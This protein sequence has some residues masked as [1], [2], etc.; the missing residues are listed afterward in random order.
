MAHD[1]VVTRPLNAVTA[2]SNLLVSCNIETLGDTPTP[3]TRNPKPKLG[4]SK[5]EFVYVFLASVV[6]RLLDPAQDKPANTNL[7]GATQ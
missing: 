6:K 1:I 4:N 3:K 7:H 2:S 5:M